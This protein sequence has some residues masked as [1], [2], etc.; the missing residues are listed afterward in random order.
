MSNPSEGL[1]DVCSDAQG[2]TW[3]GACWVCH[4]CLEEHTECANG[5][6]TVLRADGQHATCFEGDYFCDECLTRDERGRL[7]RVVLE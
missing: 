1:C 3:L 4:G 2:E 5:C 7:V 6:G